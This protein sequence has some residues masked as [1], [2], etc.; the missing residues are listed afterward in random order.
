MKKV[1]ISLLA[2]IIAMSALAKLNGDGYYRVQNFASERYIYVMD[3]KGKLNFQATTAELGA[4]ELWKNHEKTISDPA[5]IIYVTDLTGKNQDFDLQS[6][7]TGVNAIISYPV[8]IR[9]DS[10][11]GSDQYTIFGRNSGVTRYIGDGT[12]MSSDQGYVASLDNNEYYR[13]YFHPITTDGS[14]YFGINADLTDGKTNCTTFFA[15]FP[16]S[17]HSTGMKAYKVYCVQDGKAYIEE[18]TGVI[19]RATP[20]II[21]A[22]S[23]N[24]S[25]NRLSIG[26]Q[27]GAE[28]ENNLLKG[29]YFNNSVSLHINQTPY[30][31]NTMRVLGKLS[32]GSIGFKVEDIDFLPRNKAYLVV[33]EGTPKELTLSTDTPSGI[34]SPSMA[35][36]SVTIDGLTLYVSGVDKAEVYSVTGTFVGNVSNAVNGA[37]MT[38]PAA[39]VY[40]VKS[41]DSVIKISAK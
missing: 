5:T 6:Q 35:Q 36:A 18:V 12:R 21:M 20:L 4:I 30:D 27:P 29:V 16:F 22:S 9:L 23:S 39:G 41:A 38:L 7:G 8:S 15:D 10:K 2:G 34:D 28:I 33:P 13:W 31:P 24:P 37:S 25:D 3:D 1:S 40:F 11:Y 32:D 26:G 17:F 19:P 14:N